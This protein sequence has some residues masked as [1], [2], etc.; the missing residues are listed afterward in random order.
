MARLVGLGWVFF[1]KDG[2]CRFVQ[3]C[4][5]D[6]RVFINITDLAQRTDRDCLFAGWTNEDYALHPACG[7]SSLEHQ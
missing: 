2:S 6:F 4:L 3:V 7:N 5:L 1:L